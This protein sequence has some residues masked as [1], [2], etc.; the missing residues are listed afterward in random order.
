ME[1]LMHEFEIN[2]GNVS[3]ANTETLKEVENDIMKLY[4]IEIS[5]EIKQ[6]ILSISNSARLEM[7]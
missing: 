1:H 5:P 7:I 3:M 4:K 6:T 2:Y